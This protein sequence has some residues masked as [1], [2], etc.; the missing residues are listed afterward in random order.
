MK[1]QYRHFEEDFKRNLIV[2]IDSGGLTKSQAAREHNLAGSVIDRWQRQIHD[3]SMRVH[4][5]VNEKKMMHE[6][7]MYKKKVG[8]LSLQID[9]L[10]KLNETSA[11]MRRSSGYVVTGGNT[12]RSGKDAK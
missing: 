4:P 11:S 12:E 9:L 5:T 6:L 2:R 8:E 10:K 1:K 7:D 3:G